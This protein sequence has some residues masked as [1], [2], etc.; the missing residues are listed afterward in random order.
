MGPRRPWG[1]NWI[2]AR[3]PGT[4][5]ISAC[6]TSA[7]T[8]AA[9][10]SVQL[11]GMCMCRSTKWRWPALR[12][13]RWSKRIVRCL[14]PASTPWIRPAI[15]RPA[16]RPS[17]R[18]LARQTRWA[19]SRSTF[20]ATAR[21]TAASSQVPARS[22]S[23]RSGRPPR[24]RRSRRRSP[25]AGHRP[26]TPSSAV[27]RAL[28]SIAKARAAVQRRAEH[29]EAEGRGPAIRSAAAP[30]GDAPRP[31]AMPRP[32]STI[33]TPSKPPEKYS[34]LWWPKGWSS[35]GGR[36]AMVSMASAN[37]APARLTS[38]SSAS[39]AR[40][41]EPVHHQAAVLQRN[42]PRR[43]SG[44]EF[45]VGTGLHDG[46]CRRVIRAPYNPVRSSHPPHAR[47]EN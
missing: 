37:S 21:A 40:L 30:P 24:R 6:S 39:A 43:P 20:S 28:R 46:Y 11:A 38:D 26:P 47:H 41:T 18:K 42:G 15:R 44:R 25:G 33:R 19:P 34:A 35:S 31:Q 5:L 10:P 36:A 1:S 8:A 14:N 27:S 16:P 17:G 4:A 12:L 45:Q 7:R 2:V 13:A 29:G 9:R 22:A 32:A 23:R 3:S